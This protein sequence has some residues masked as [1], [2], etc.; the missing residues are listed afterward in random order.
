MSAPVAAM[1]KLQLLTG[2]RTGE[3]MVMR[4]IDL[5][6]A[7]PVWTYAPH[8]HKNQHRGKERVIYLGP[9]AQVVVKPFLTTDLSA[10]LFSPTG[11]VRE[12]RERQAAARKTKRTP[13]E[14][15][16]RRCER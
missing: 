9:Q 7:G 12:L 6:T 16:R 13:S 1:V 3:A 11:Y 5:N 2:C 14:L 8:R 4:A 10:Y 15:L